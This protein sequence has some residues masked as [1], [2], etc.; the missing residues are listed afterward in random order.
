M[1]TKIAERIKELRDE[2]K[3]NQSDLAKEIGV[4]QSAV[5]QWEAEINEPKASYILLLAY[6]FDVSTDYLL[7]KED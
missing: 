6:F 1:K 5:S 4:A 3:I 2:K 7:G